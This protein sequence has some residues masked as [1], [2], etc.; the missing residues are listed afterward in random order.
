VSV[1]KS[2]KDTAVLNKTL[3]ELQELKECKP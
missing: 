1:V 3:G 2:I